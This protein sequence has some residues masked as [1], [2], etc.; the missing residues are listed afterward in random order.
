M[1]Y[2]LKSLVKAMNK[3]TLIFRHEF[4]SPIRRMGFIIMTLIVPLIAILGIVIY[5][6]VSGVAQPSEKITN[7]GYVDTVGGF[8][9]YTTQGNINLVRFETIDEANKSLAAKDIEEYIVKNRTRL[10]LP[11]V[12]Y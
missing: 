12:V 10:M 3:T 7:I 6:I 5:Q 8:E 9:Q 4:L 1:T 11:W 2:L